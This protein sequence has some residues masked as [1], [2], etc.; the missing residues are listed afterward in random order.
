MGL[1]LALRGH[2]RALLEFCLYNSPHPGLVWYVYSH[3][4]TLCKALGLIIRTTVY[5][6]LDP[7]KGTGRLAAYI[8]GI[9]VGGI[10]LYL[11]MW[12]VTKLRDWTFRQGR[13]VKVIDLSEHQS[14]KMRIAHV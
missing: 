9:A 8:V 11:V 13:G 3:T 14:E 10:V 5:G 7:A 4:L 12:A 2:T 1:P 6:F